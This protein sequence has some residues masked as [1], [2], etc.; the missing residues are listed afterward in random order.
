MHDTTEDDRGVFW[1]MV[2]MAVSV[3][4]FVFAVVGRIGP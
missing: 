1:L 2:S 3:S 4:V